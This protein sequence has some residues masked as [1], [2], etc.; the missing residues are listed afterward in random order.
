[1]ERWRRPCI[2]ANRATIPQK[3]PL[4][5]RNVADSY[6]L[7][8]L[9]KPTR[10]RAGGSESSSRRWQSGRSARARPRKRRSPSRNARRLG[11]RKK[12]RLRSCHAGGPSLSSLI[13]SLLQLHVNLEWCDEIKLSNLLLPRM[14][15]T[16]G[17]RYR[18]YSRLHGSHDARKLA[19]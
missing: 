2:V 17:L 6:G 9:T 18:G 8:E 19:K 14:S 4:P 12:M 7:T 13:S 3:W 11:R 1:M 5:P 10:T 15:G 16:G